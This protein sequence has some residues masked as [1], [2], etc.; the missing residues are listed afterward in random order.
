LSI[1]NVV[2]VGSPQQRQWVLVDAGIGGTAPQILAAGEE[3]FAHPPEAII[4]TH[5][6]FDHVGALQ[7]LLQKWDVPVFAHPREHPFL[8][9]EQSYPAP[10]VRSGGGA[11]ALLS[12]LFPREPIDISHALRALPDDGTVPFLPGWQWIHTPGHTPGHISLWRESDRSLIAGDAFVTTGQESAYE[13]MMQAPQM[14]GPPRYF[15]SDWAAAGASVRTLAALAPRLVITGHGR[16][17][18]GPDMLSALMELADRF[19]ELAVPKH[20]RSTP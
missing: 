20:K 3:R 6:H 1:V 11:V 2:F 12:P 7:A 15:T 18:S 5:G 8:N 9:G 17:M 14:H 19:E 13:V 4:L 16:A 10:D